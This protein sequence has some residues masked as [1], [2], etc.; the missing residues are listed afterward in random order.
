[1]K[2]CYAF[3]VGFADGML[4]ALAEA[5]GRDRNF[6]VAAAVFAQASVEM[7]RMVEVLGGRRETVRW[8]P[9]VGD[10]YVTSMGGRN[11]RAG[12]LVGSGMRFSEARATMPG[13][14]LEGI[15][16]IEVIGGALPKLTERGILARDDLPLLR[17]LHAVVTEDAEADF[18]WERFFR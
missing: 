13:V 7:A 3:G 12:R 1:M 14:T 17:R 8:L 6:N 15:A 10:L 16:A 4:E 18:P 2:N 11:V 9:G 5:Q